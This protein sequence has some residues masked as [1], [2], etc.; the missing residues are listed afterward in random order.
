MKQAVSYLVGAVVIIATVVYFSS[1]NTKEELPP[2]EDNLFFVEFVIGSDTIYY[3][4]GEDNYGNGPGVQSDSDSIGRLHSQYST[5]I[6]SALS[7]NFEDNTFSIQMVK[8]FTDT[9]WPSYNTEFLLFDE[10]NYEY[11]SW[12]SDSTHLGMDGVVFTYTD[13]DSKVWS[14]DTLYGQQEGTEIFTIIDHKA[15]DVAVF[16]AKTKGIFRCRVFDGLGGFLDLE[17]GS[18]HARTILKP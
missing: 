9:S 1:C 3:E 16:G 14:S 11:G 10:G 15:V 18:F 13:N 2:G 4:D 5:F 6:R 12:N 8:F 7:P 17:S